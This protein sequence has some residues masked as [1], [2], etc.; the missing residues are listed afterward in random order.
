MDRRRCAQNVLLLLLVSVLAA[1]CSFSS[2]STAV[3][4]IEGYLYW[5]GAV[6]SKRQMR[7]GQAISIGSAGTV[8]EQPLAEAVVVIENSQISATTDQNGYFQI[9]GLNPGRT[10]I[11]ITSPLLLGSLRGSVQVKPNAITAV[12]NDAFA[13]GHYMLVGINDYGNWTGGNS[14]LLASLVGPVN[15]VRAM[16]QVLVDEDARSRYGNP[17]RYQV[18]EDSAATAGGILQAIENAGATMSSRYDYLVLYFSGH[19]MRDHIVAYDA[20]VSD[21]QI[22]D[23]LVSAGVKRATIIIDTCNSGSFVDGNAGWTPRSTNG[24]SV[25]S[26]SLLPSDESAQ[27]AVITSSELDENSWEKYF[28]EVRQQRGWFSYELIKAIKDPKTDR[29]SD[30]L[31]TSG[32]IHQEIR[33]LDDGVRIQNV[34]LWG[35]PDTVIYRR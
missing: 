26:L 21:T 11:A 8:A 13:R 22:K 16:K 15:D 5:S 31:L 12:T 19:G 20:Y 32:E 30:G 18:L 3:G 10:E 24:V 14:P 6:E 7:A 1:G 4:S 2:G 33:V 29:N 17:A 28:P 9:T 25:R 34:V 27:Y 23:A 35:D